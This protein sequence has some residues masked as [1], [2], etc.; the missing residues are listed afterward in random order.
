MDSTTGRGADD[1]AGLGAELR[2]SVILL[3]LC[4]TV[5]AVVTVAAQASL[6]LFG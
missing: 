5:T 6:A 1:D 4:L 2:E 3:G